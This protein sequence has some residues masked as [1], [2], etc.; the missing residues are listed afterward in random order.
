MSCSL[1]P[2]RSNDGSAGKEDTDSTGR[3]KVGD[4]ATGKLSAIKAL[5]SPVA[6]GGTLSSSGVISESDVG[7][8]GSSSI[9]VL[10]PIPGATGAISGPSTDSSSEREYDDDDDDVV[11]LGSSTR[12]QVPASRNQYQPNTI[13]ALD[14]KQPHSHINGQNRPQTP[15][16]PI[17]PIGPHPPRS[18]PLFKWIH[19]LE[20]ESSTPS[21]E[22]LVG[23]D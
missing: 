16:A 22:A 20:S 8:L 11:L 5:T 4:A 19:S 3:I 7:S 18:T 13:R 23:R 9:D 6:A 10:S 1:T 14:Y 15:G 21:E 17:R 12:N 2:H